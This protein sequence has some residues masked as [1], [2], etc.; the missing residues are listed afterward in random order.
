MQNMTDAVK[1]AYNELLNEK[2]IIVGDAHQGFGLTNENIF[3]LKD[4][5]IIP[6]SHTVKP[7]VIG[8][9]TNVKDELPKYDENGDNGYLVICKVGD[10]YVKDVGWFLKST[11][12][13]TNEIKFEWCVYNDWDE[14]Q[15]CEVVYWMP[16]PDFPDEVKV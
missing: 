16:W 8:V 6:L 11:Y 4:G 5:E 10:Q 1:K 9:W 14:G 12:L 15:G 2:A 13:E 7:T 3:L